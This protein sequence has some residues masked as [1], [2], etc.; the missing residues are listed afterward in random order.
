GFSLIAGNGSNYGVVFAGLKP[1]SYRVPRGQDIIT[2]LTTMRARFAEIQEGFV[3]AFYLPAVEGVGSAAG[4]DLRLED[5][6]GVGR[7]QMQQFVQELVADGNAQSKLRRVS[8]P[9]KAAVAQLF[10]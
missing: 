8:T 4:F 7:D 5:R 9:Y 6:G 3:L 2:L 10:A 1:W